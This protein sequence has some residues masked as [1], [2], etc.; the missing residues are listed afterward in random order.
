MDTQIN[1][2]NKESLLT[3]SNETLGIT[4]R[5]RNQRLHRK[6]LF[7]IYL[8]TTSSFCPNI[9]DAWLCKSK[10]KIVDVNIPRPFCKCFQ[11]NKAECDKIDMVFY[12]GMTPSQATTVINKNNYKEEK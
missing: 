5:W 4:A 9:D 11:I 2:L 10:D 6:C 1:E 3:N 12:N 8:T 7:C